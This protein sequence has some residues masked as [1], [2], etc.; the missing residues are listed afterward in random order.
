MVVM[1]KAILDSRR[2]LFSPLSKSRMMHI[3]KSWRMFGCRLASSES[4]SKALS[5]A[6]PI[7]LMAP[8]S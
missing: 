3:A 6:H 8:G 5:K 4:P 2:G 1:N 7:V